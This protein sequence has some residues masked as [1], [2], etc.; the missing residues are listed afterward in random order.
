MLYGAMAELTRDLP[1]TMTPASALERLYL[2]HR[3]PVVRYLRAVSPSEDEAFEVAG[4]VFERALG[5]LVRDPSAE[6]GL[7]GLLRTA[8]NA[9]VDQSRRRRVRL[10]AVAA[11]PSSAPEPSPESGYLERERALAVRAALA[12]LPAATRDAIVLRYALGLPA[13]AIAEIIGRREEATQKLISRGL[14]RLREALD[15]TR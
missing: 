13:R 15:D 9:S 6:L 8:R 14:A 5:V 3:D 12:T 1:L 2:A 10:V 4:I 7:P 11:L